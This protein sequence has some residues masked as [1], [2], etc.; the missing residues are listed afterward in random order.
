MMHRS[1]AAFALTLLSAPALCAAASPAPTDVTPAVAARIDGALQAVT[2]NAKGS[3]PALSV[4]VV[5]NG[6][7]VYAHAFGVSD[8]AAKTP[9]TPKTRFRIASVT[10]M[11]TAVAVMQLVEAGRVR[12]DAP[13]ATYLPDAPYATKV[14]IRE[15]LMHT[16]GIW[17]YGDEAFTSGRVATPTTPRDI[18]ASVAERAGGRT[19]HPGATATRDTFCSAWRWR[20]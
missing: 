16:S 12:L 7:L 3:S 15:L 13:L 9:A 20:R 18:V 2:G 19:R 1:T 17:N 5:E 6:R 10:K 14:T 8:V 4:A 11:F